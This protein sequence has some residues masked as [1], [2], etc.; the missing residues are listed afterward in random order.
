MPTTAK[1][2]FDTNIVRASYF[3]DIHERT[4]E[5]VGAPSRARRELPRGAVVF[6]VGALDAFISE[7]SAEVMVRQLEAAMPLPEQREILRRMQSELPTLALETALIP[8]HA[9]R[10]FRIHDSI[11]AYFQN[12]VSNLGSKAVSAAVMRIGGRPITLWNEVS[13]LWPKAAD[14]LDQWTEVRHKIVHRGEKPR[15]WRPHARRLI[16]L[17]KAIASSLDSIAQPDP[18][19]PVG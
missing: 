12:N 1:R 4:Q 17:V 5:G 16:E 2:I 6:A 10:V 8:D 18:D 3:L 14:E 13:A 9:D 15:V 7:L 11:V 19:E